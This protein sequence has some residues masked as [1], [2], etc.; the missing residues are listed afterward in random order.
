LQK[1]A[2]HRYFL[3]CAHIHPVQNSVIVVIYPVH[4]ASHGNTPH[5]G[6]RQKQLE[7][8][9]MNCASGDA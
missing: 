2:I 1:L 5:L 6:Y 9:E 3:R 7:I 8:K 4:G